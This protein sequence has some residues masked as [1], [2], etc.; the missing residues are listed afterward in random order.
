MR[1]AEEFN[2]VLRLIATGMNDCAVARMTGVPR[3]T[4]RDWRCRPH[5]ACATRAQHNPAEFCMISRHSQQRSTHTYW[6][7]I[8][9]TA[10]S[11]GLAEFGDCAFSWTRNTPRSLT[12]A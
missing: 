7:C 10:A 4:I 8:S 11:L 5:A 1:S 12:D 3:P 6:G 2:E 9:A